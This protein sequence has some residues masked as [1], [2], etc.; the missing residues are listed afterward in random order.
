MKYDSWD[1]FKF[2]IVGASI[3]SGRSF[4]T[5]GTDTNKRLK[6]DQIVVVRSSNNR[7]ARVRGVSNVASSDPDR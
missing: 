1:D 5:G 2:F 7:V 4:W 6:D 3:A